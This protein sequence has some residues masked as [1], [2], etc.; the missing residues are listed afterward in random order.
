MK[1]LVILI[2]GAFGLMTC[3]PARSVPPEGPCQEAE[4][5]VPSSY[6]YNQLNTD[7]CPHPDQKATVVVSNL[8]GWYMIKCKCDWSL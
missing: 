4:Y 8:E 1:H 5:Y 2:L 7:I 3:A 6:P